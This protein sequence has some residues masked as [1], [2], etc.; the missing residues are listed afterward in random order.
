MGERGVYFMDIKIK[1][2]LNMDISIP[3]C[4]SLAHNRAIKLKI[5]GILKNFMLRVGTE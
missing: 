2:M 1:K 3:L 4:D 5:S